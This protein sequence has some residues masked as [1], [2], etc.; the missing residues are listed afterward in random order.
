LGLLSG[1]LSDLGNTVRAGDT[2]GVPLCSLC[3][4]EIPPGARR[5]PGCGAPVAPWITPVEVSEVAE[6][7]AA[8][9]GWSPAPR[10]APPAPG[11]GIAPHPGT[12]RRGSVAAPGPPV[13]RDWPGAVR[14]AALAA[15]ATYVVA[16]GL[17]PLLA[18]PASPDAVLWVTAPSALLA[19]AMGG[20]WQASAPGAADGFGAAAFGYQV[21]AFPLTLTALLVVVLAQAVRTRLETGRANDTLRDRMLQAVRV[22][23]ALA[24]IGLLAGLLSRH[25][26]GDLATHAGYLAAPVGGLLLGAGTSAVVA[27]GYDVSQL[28]PG[29]RRL[30]TLLREP[31]RVLRSVLLVT[32]ICGVLGALLA[33]EAAPADDLVVSGD[34]RRALSGIVI[35]A[36]PNVGWW[37]LAACLGVPV[38]VDLLSG[39]HGAGGVL[40]LGDSGWWL[41]GVALALSLLVAAGFRLT[42]GVTGVAARHRWWTWTGLVALTAA[43][44]ALLGSLRVFG[45][46]GSFPVEY[47]VGSTSPLAALL[48]PVWAALCALAAYGIGRL[49]PRPATPPG[50]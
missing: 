15:L 42:P 14:A 28:P 37:F 33:L 6:Q 1:A 12:A 23:V 9:E 19:V 5:C 18:P 26:V 40:Q 47:R 20:H 10:M 17:A 46:V 41:P 44:F 32:S 7:Q 30:W 43:G 48:P 39:R 25:Q 34:Y 45:G 11:S 27:A 21:H 49:L 2:G 50:P 38:R 24:G 36:G 13:R 22:G 29:A 8:A 31:A 16:A 3:A 35:A 4:A